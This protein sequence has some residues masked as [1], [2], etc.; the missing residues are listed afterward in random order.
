MFR[1][2]IQASL[3]AVND[4]ESEL[5]GDHHPVAKR[6]ESFAYKHGVP[7]DADYVFDVRVLPNPHYVRELRP[8]KRRPA[9]TEIADNPRS[10][11]AVLRAVEKLAS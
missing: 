11:S 9:A 3:F 7:L 2:A 1:P 8:L 4:L 5:G 10:E 6:S